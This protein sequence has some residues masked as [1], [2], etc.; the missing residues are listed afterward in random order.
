MSI[1]IMALSAF[2]VGLLSG[3]LAQTPW[4]LLGLAAIA[5][6][7]LCMIADLVTDPTSH[8]L[9]PFELVMYG[10][11][12]IPAILAAGLGRIPRVLI[13]SRHKSA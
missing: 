9:F 4:A 10:A 11:F 3:A 2:I 12:S 6:F 7:P 8:N 1:I 5:V 13:I